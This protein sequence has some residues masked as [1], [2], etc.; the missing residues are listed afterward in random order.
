MGVNFPFF[1]KLR[2]V[3]KFLLF[4]EDAPKHRVVGPDL[5]AIHV[6]GMMVF[7]FAVGCG[8]AYVFT[9]GFIAMC[10]YAVSIPFIILEMLHIV[11]D[12]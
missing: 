8:A 7:A 11:F 2:E 6:A 12:R 4:R 10:V 5:S 1:R 9:Y 3:M